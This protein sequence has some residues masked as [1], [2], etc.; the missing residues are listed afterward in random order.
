ML[1]KSK[2]ALAVMCLTAF[3]NISVAQQGTIEMTSPGFSNVALGPSTSPVAVMM[4]EDIQNLTVNTHFK[5]LN[6]AL[7][8]TTSFANQQYNTVY[9][10][11]STGICFGGGNTAST[12]GVTQ[13]SATNPIYNALGASLVQPPQN[14]MFVSS[15][16]G[17]IVSNWQAGGR[18]VG[19]DPEGTQNGFDD[20]LAS[21]DY[22]FGQAIFTTVEPLWDLNLPKDGRYYYGDIVIN[23]SRPVQ[24][25][26]IHIGGLGGS[27]NYQP[28]SGGPRLIS[29]FSSELEL[30][31]A[32]VTST[33]MAG[34]EN[35]SI[36]GNKI[37][38]SSA[39][40]NGGSYN[41]GG[42]QG[43][44]LTYGAAT[45][46]V[47]INGTVTR[48]V[49][50]VFVRGSV[51]S[52]FNFSQN[53]SAISG[54]T[55]DPL[56][57]D[58]FYLALSL[59]KPNQQISG[60][61]YNDRDGLTDNNIN[62]SFGVANP[63]TNVND[64]IYAILRNAGGQAVASTPVGADGAYLFDNVPVGTYTVQLTNVP[65]AGTYAVPVA[66]PA[67]ALPAG[68]VNT[69]E[70][71]GAGIGSDGVVNGVSANIVLGAGDI[72]TE[73]NY[74]IERLPESNDYTH[75]ITK[76]KIGDVLTLHDTLSVLKGSDPEDQPVL[77][78][79]AGKSL[80]ITSLPQA[81]L[82][83]NGTPLAVGSVITNYNP[84]LLQIV[85]DRQPNPPGSVQFNYATID[86]AG[87]QDPTPGL[88]RLIF[89]P[90]GPLAITLSQFTAV[91]NNCMASL[92]WK[93]ASEINADRFE[94][95]LST[96]NG[97]NY[98][99]VGT[100]MATGVAGNIYQYNYP[101]QTG[102]INYFRLKMLDK[103]GSY[104]Y[105]DIRQLS[106]GSRSFDILINPNP[107]ISRFVISGMQTGRN[108]VSIY[109]A[110][111]QLVYTT[112]LTQTTA[113]VD[114]SNLARAMYTV[115]I[116]SVKGDV[117]VMKLIKE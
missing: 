78:T 66:P 98:T 8:I 10:N 109:A 97:V 88:Y 91:K 14:G 56:N 47:R 20:D 54:A 22:S 75:L 117:F 48:L 35:F 4:R 57:G 32:G 94:V 52:D 39:T 38:N 116:T 36:V 17:T 15:P 41:D 18:G 113:T 68:W 40:P 31:N 111:G 11:L 51:N 59:N 69:G 65:S 29:Y 30:Q 25:P 95:E 83:Y 34:N 43:G 108:T 58:L 71:I 13:T 60:F 104:K 61:V 45:G 87:K 27:Y 100:V 70:F 5:T 112:V 84:A 107:V 110:N 90:G 92:E 23:F 105:S 55:R 81:L 21:F 28:I 73:V 77:G 16:T 102:V 80:R 72:R 67:T 93:T 74:G 53:M 79:W 114:I 85:F 89:F 7:T 62:Q 86:A 1:R 19:L 96:D 3:A 46:S 26:V 6:P 2:L 49:Y 33:F 64:G 37:L 106:C 103:D 63:V 50:K 12:G 115:K 101:M 9:G 44:F 76:P 82:R 42:T 24:N 99:K